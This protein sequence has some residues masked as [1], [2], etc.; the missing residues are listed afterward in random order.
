VTR[1]V[2]PQFSLA[3][4]LIAM[5]WSGVAVRVNTT[6]YILEH[7]HYATSANVVQVDYSKSENVFGPFGYGWP[8]RF[9]WAS[10][11]YKLS[12]SDRFRPY[13]MWSCGRLVGDAAVGVLLV[14]VLTWGSTQLLRRVTSR[15]RRGR[16]PPCSTN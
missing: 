3:T 13:W 10:H 12:D 15:F 9:A 6:P 16:L 11:F 2:R 5:A 4:L 8:W 14:A 1:F 7:W